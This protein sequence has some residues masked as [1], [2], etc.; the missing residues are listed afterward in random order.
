MSAKVRT[1]LWFEK[2]GAE[3]ARFYVSLLPDSWMEGEH[4]L[5]QSEP[6]LVDFTLAGA[7]FQILNG[8]PHFQLSEAASIS[9]IVSDQA[10]LD[11]LWEALCADG[12]DERQCGWLKD[13][14]GVFWQIYPR[15]LLDMQSSD[16]QAA[17]ERVRQAMY[18]MKRLDIARL[19]TAFNGR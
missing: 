14:W 17:A 19:E 1:C 6:M 5:G 8:G 13:R 2:G 11:R 16:D 18:A 4:E 7:P 15:A 9:V 3:A 10:E 12:G